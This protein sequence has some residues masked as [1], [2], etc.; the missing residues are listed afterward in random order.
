[1]KSLS[2][3]RDENA[4]V[5]AS[6]SSRLS[7]TACHDHRMHDDDEDAAVDDVDANKDDR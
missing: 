4:S 3:Q 2:S 7:P 5:T 1:M 6:A